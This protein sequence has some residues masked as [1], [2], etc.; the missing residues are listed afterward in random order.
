MEIVIGLVGA[1]GAGKT[2]AFKAMQEALGEVAQEITL[3]D[4]LKNACC[5]VF[6][7]PRNHFDSHDFKEKELDYPVFLTVANV[8]QIFEDYDAPVKDP[9]FYNKYIRSHV[10]TVL[11]TP[12]KVAQYIG[13]EVLRAW[14]PDIHCEEAVKVVIKDV[15]IVTDMRFPNEFQYFKDN[16]KSFIPV[17]IQNLA[18]EV[19][20]SKDTHASEQHL[21][22]L[23][24]QCVK[25]LANNTTLKEFQDSV[26]VF[27]KDEL[28]V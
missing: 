7:I 24:K 17:Y 13:T 14:R 27:I 11:L 5:A 10:G 22:S 23:A 3:A 26:K 21:K 12:R 16:Y 28:H 4:Q 6:S 18:A 19:E 9:D 20:A 15:G 2:T 8:T 1:K 25:T